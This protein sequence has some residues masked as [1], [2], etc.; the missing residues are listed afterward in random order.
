MT[1][2]TTADERATRAAVLFPTSLVGSYPQPGW[3]IDRDRLLGGSHAHVRRPDLWLD[4]PGAAVRGAKDDAARPR[5]VADQLAA[6]HRSSSPMARAVVRAIRTGSPP[7]ST[8]STSRNT[9]AFGSR[10]HA[11]VANRPMVQYPRR[12]PDHPPWAGRARRG[13]VPPHAHRQADQGHRSRP[14]HDVPAGGRRL[15]PTT[16]QRFAIAYAEAVVNAEVA[17]SCFAAGADVVQIDEKPLH[18]GATRAGAPSAWRRSRKGDRGSAL[19]PSRCTCASA[20]QRSFMT[21]RLPTRSS[22]SSRARRSI[23]SRSRPRSQTSDCAPSSSPSGDKDD[24][25]RRAST[26]RRPQV[27]TPE[28]DRLP[29]QSSGRLARIR[30]RRSVS[31]S[32]RTAEMKFSARAPMTAAGKLQRQAGRAPAGNPRGVRYRGRSARLSQPLSRAPAGAL[33]RAGGAD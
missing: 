9:Q 24:H 26:S 6:R 18:G 10:P 33:E 1:T 14:V 16:R 30:R 31:I 20:T 11:S 2:V 22:K 19:A 25:P 15:L 12:R 17:R 5:G 4:R 27:E 3:L 7:R 8:A 29:A 13:G 23:R 32:P 28:V 21:A